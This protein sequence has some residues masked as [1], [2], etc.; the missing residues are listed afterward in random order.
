[1]QW[2][3]VYEKLLF[4]NFLILFVE[5]WKRKIGVTK[6]FCDD[7]NNSWAHQNYDLFFFS[8]QIW[9]VYLWRKHSP[10]KWQ[11]NFLIRSWTKFWNNNYFWILFRNSSIKLRIIIDEKN[12]KL[13]SYYLKKFNLKIIICFCFPLFF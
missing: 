3:V 13:K 1:M 2:W 8:S 10:I 4:W 7:S 12:I 5:K 9:N 6:N 11:C